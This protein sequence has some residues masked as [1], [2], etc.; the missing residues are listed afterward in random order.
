[1]F[2]APKIKEI[3]VN[4]NIIDDTKDKKKHIFLCPLFLPHLN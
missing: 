1:M 4:E 2:K 3:K